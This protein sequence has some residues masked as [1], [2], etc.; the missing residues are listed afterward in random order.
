MKICVLFLLLLQGAISQSAANNDY[1]GLSYSLEDISLSDGVS[2]AIHP[3]NG[4]V[5]LYFREN[6]HILQLSESGQ[7]DTLSTFS[8]EFNNRQV[9]DV[10]PNGEELLLWDSGLGRVHSLDLNTTEITRLD[11]S[12]NHMNQFGHA[13]TLG[14]DGNIYAMGGYGYWEFKNHLIYYSQADRQWELHSKPDPDIVPKNNGGRLFRTDDTFY[15]LIKPRSTGTLHSSVFKYLPGEHRW[16]Q[17]EQLTQ[18]LSE[19]ALDVESTSSV[20]EQTSTY[21]I[22]H[23]RNLIGVLRYTRSQTHYAYLIDYENSRIFELDLSQLNIYDAKNIF[24]VPGKDHWVILGHPFS[25][26]QRDQLILR[27]IEF[28]ESNPALTLISGQDESNGLT[29][30]VLTSIGGLLLILFGWGVYRNIFSEKTRGSVRSST[31]KKSPVMEFTEDDNTGEFSVFLNGKKFNYTGDPYLTKMME[32]I[33]EMKKEASPEILISNLDQKLFSNSLHTSYKSRMRR[34]VIEIINEESNYDLI[35][36]K[37]SQ[38]D[39][40][41]K[42]VE[43]KLAKI[44]ITSQGV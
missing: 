15:Y 4:N 12:H 30:I 37:K 21:A 10:H 24:Y 14:E 36:E 8:V 26:N 40:R 34:K 6:G 9:I 42:V 16:V 13:A 19:K 22:D 23:S 41:V 35:K 7:V 44:K 39:K 17:D 2:V 1:S 31:S 20:F 3:E 28:D 29:P 32:L 5:Y 11:E 27:T 38:T 33:F 43:L 25:T 18:I